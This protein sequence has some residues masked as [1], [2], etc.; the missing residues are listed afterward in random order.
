VLQ[1]RNNHLYITLFETETLPKYYMLSPN[2][3][4]KAELIVP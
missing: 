4:L 2:S 1:D 3:E